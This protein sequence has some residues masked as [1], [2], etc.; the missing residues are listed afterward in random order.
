MLTHQTDNTISKEAYNVYG[1][2][3]DLEFFPPPQFILN[4]IANM[5]GKM[6]V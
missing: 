3:K 2:P 5:L 1:S 4:H 6:H